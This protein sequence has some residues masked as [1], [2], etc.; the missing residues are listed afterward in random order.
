M[1]TTQ[2]AK[3]TRQSALRIA[4]FDLVERCTHW[5]VAV[6]FGVLIFTAIPLY[7]GTLFGIVLP[8][9]TYARLHLWCGLALP[10]PIIVSL[11]GRWGAAMRADVARISNWT[12]AERRWVRSLGR[13]S[14]K[15]GKFN[16]GQKLNATF[17]AA[18]ILTMLVT[19]AILQWFRFFPVQVR[20]NAT[21]VHDVVAFAVVILITGHILMAVAHRDSLVSMF[22]GTISSRWASR[23][24]PAWLD[25][26]EQAD[27]KQ[28]A[29]TT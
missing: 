7:F 1:T 24:A 4:R 19:G 23:H 12:R 29:D 25:E 26:V 11:V 21:F 18:T 3:T 2:P 16:P 14:L 20:V 15:A 5:L 28:D 22:R 6:L 27:G 10:L 9:Q 17:I 13:A 8:R